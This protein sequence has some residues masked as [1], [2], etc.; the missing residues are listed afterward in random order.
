M[1]HQT[2]AEATRRL[3]GAAGEKNIHAYADIKID[4]P[5]LALPI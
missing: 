2:V 1:I 3:K 5:L 4:Q